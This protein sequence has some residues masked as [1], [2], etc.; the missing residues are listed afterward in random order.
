MKGYFTRRRLLIL[1][2]AA[3]LTALLTLVLRDFVRENVVLPLVNLGWIAWIGL[4]SVPQAIYWGGFLLLAI[5]IAVRSFS[6]GPNRISSR[7]MRPVQRYSSPSRYTYWQTG[8]RS[9]SHSSFAHERVE[10]EL[11]NL[12]IQILAEQRRLA[13][14]ELREQL[15]QGRLDLSSEQQIIRDLFELSPHAILDSP[16]ARFFGLVG[17]FV[18]PLHAPHRIQIG[19]CRC[20]GMVGGANWQSCLK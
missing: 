2:S 15:F 13:V 20:R 5:I 3:V 8:L 18:G 10:R 1:L 16:S 6:Y 4:L 12:V 7:F 9:I 17:A 11:Q 19:Y 14:E